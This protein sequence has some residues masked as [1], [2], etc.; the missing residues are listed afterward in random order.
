MS[1][2]CCPTRNPADVK[3][4]AEALWQQNG[5]VNMGARNAFVEYGDGIDVKSYPVSDYISPEQKARRKH[6]A[7]YNKSLRASV[8]A[9]AAQS[10]RDDGLIFYD[11]RQAP[12]KAVAEPVAEAPKATRQ[13][14]TAKAVEQ[15]TDKLIEAMDIFWRV[16]RSDLPAFLSRFG[17][18]ADKAAQIA[19]LPNLAAVAR[20]FLAVTA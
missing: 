5:F 4:W 20:E 12:K 3:A 11:F 2:T 15:A 16:P 7:M 9:E 8:M 19:T 13:R 10:V 1:Y 17:I 6:L 14:R 18:A